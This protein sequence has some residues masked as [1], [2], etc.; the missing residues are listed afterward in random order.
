MFN[1]IRNDDDGDDDDGD[2][3][4]DDDYYYNWRWLNCLR[5]GRRLKVMKVASF[6]FHFISFIGDVK[7]LFTFT[8]KINIY[9]YINYSNFD[10]TNKHH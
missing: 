10:E 1:S 2:N 5:D 9:I 7:Y 3:G 8:N 4:D 6:F